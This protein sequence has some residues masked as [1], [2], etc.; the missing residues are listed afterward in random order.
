MG[1]SQTSRVPVSENNL[2]VMAAVSHNPRSQR[3]PALSN[4]RFYTGHWLHIL[5]MAKMLYRYNI[6]IVDPFP[7]RTE[8]FLKVAHEMILEA[9]TIYRD[10]NTDAVLSD[11]K[12]SFACSILAHDFI[13]TYIANK[14]GIVALVSH[15]KFTPV[16]II[17]CP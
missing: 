16:T 17:H 5:S 2:N 9:A 12:L 7:E 13:E 11:G 3:E 10:V 14:D 1:T 15:D 6:H 4:L 8:E